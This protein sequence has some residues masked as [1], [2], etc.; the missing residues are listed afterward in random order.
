MAGRAD[1]CQAGMDC[2]ITVILTTN[3]FT[4]AALHFRKAALFLFLGFFPHL[5]SCHVPS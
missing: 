1:Y 2:R 4:W 3:L 5:E